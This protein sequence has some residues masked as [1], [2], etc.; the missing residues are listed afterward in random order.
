MKPLNLKSINLSGLHLIEASAGTGKTWTIAA[1]YI[2]LLLEKELRPEQILVV[3][4]T[5]SATAELRD[6]IRQRISSLL[7]LYS[8]QRTASDD[9]L[10]QILMQERRPDPDRARRLL[11]R[12]LHSFDD[13]AIFTIHGFCQRAL[14]ENAFES[15][16]L[17]DSEMSSD[18]SAVVRQ[19]CDDFW[20][21]NILARPNDF[22]EHLVAGEFTPEKLAKPFEGHYQNP[23]LSVIPVTAPPDIAPLI[24]Q[25]ASL[26]QAVGRLW[27]AERSQIIAQLEGDS[28]NRTSYKPEQISAAG[29]LLDSWL[30]AD[31]PNAPCSKLD[32]FSAGNI[33]SKRTKATVAI[34]DH[35]FFALCQQ[36]SETLNLIEQARRDMIIA[37]R[38][39]LR[40]WLQNELSKRKKILNTRSFDDLLL[41]LHLALEAANG[42]AL[43]DVLRQR[44]PAALIDEFQDTDPLQWNIFSR[45]LNPLPSREGECNY[46]LFLIGD[47]KQAIYSFRGAD[48]FAYL[49]AGKSVIADNRQTL[50]MNF[51]SVPAL[52]S[53][54]NTIFNKPDLNPFQHKDIIF[55]PVAA[56]TT[57]ADP[58]SCDSSPALTPFHIWI[59]P[60]PDQTKAESKPAASARITSAVAAEIYR[61]LEQGCRDADSSETQPR[62]T[63]GDVAVLVKSHRQAA[64]VQQALRAIGI[65]SVQQGSATIF[66][67]E[68]AL[69]MLRILRAAAWPGNERMVREALLTPSIGLT[70]NEI[71]AFVDSSGDHPGWE[72]WLLRFRDLGMAHRSGGVTALAAQ[73]L[74]NCGVR[75]RQLS[76]AGGERALTNI[77]HCMEMLHQAE[78][79]HGKSLSGTISWL[80]RQISGN[81]GDDAALQRL[82]TDDN[83]VRIAT[84]HA[85]KGLEYP[86]VFVPFAWDPPATRSGRV[87]YHDENGR[88]VLDL[89]EAEEHKILAREER[90]AEAVRLLYVAL[91]RARYRCYIVWGSI[92]GAVD[93]AL[94]NLLH[95][96]I[97]KRE[98]KALAELPDSVILEHVRQAAG[99]AAN[100]IIAEM[101]PEAADNLR[102]NDNSQPETPYTCRTLAHIPGDNWR[103]SSFSGMISGAGHPF[104]PR[105]HDNL[106]KE[107]ESGT[108]SGPEASGG[109]T[110]FE[111]PRGAKAGTCL[112]EI[113]EQLDF[114]SIK[115]GQIESVSGAVL[116]ANGFSGQWLPAVSQMVMDVATAEIIPGLPG[117]SLSQLKQGAWQTELEFYLPVRQLDPDTVRTLFDGLLDDKSA[118][119][120]ELLESLSFQRSRGMLQGFIDLVFVH[121]GR[122]YLLDWKSNHLGNSQGDYGREQMQQAMCRNA[123]ILQ[124]HLYTLALDRL[125]KLRLP[126]YDYETHFG[127]ALYL[128][129][130]GLKT[131]G[132]GSGI[133][134]A[135][136]SLEFIQRADRTMLTP[137]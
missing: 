24:L 93:S 128:F 53:A 3:T 84:I 34:P 89:A 108:G 55:E 30:A 105:D 46:P 94:F 115:K 136:P 35:P 92:N 86:I 82:E 49:N 96:G 87:M 91:T 14:L 74:D 59:Y 32:L 122:Y 37:C 135:R 58:F 54:V 69:D 132:T 116:A 131:T 118:D 16:S 64:D 119:F 76:S 28:L 126:G 123:Y 111:F 71:S 95:G 67:S 9:E 36:L 104:L 17:F 78:L 98:N 11:T 40:Q 124:Y 60:R 61:L 5:R 12:A 121:A 130:R 25:R 70:A 120:Q 114:S 100:G 6:R 133:F 20:R 97:L 101:M 50:G 112:H 26:F 44:Y 110:I 43:A 75:K 45:L 39:E 117:F 80:E 107:V 79:E 38:Q 7:E 99:V 47:P 129:L 29:Q 10:E 109:L 81:H 134:H 137:V 66:E 1:L 42:A 23:E 51:R 19:V 83:A 22:I 56:G 41:D 57:S 2:L 8:G 48:L 113:F 73:L 65:P 31:N 106:A 127:G 68:E 33:I 90:E 102:Y 125:L 18:Q 4:Y 63:P 13:A 62:I 85:S 52:V 103:V 77:L 88:L 27:N 72:E 21:K 15:G